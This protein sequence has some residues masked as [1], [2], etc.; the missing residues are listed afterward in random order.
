VGG[1]LISFTCKNS[2]VSSESHR[3]KRAGRFVKELQKSQKYF[4]TGCIIG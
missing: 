3:S 4:T 1:W 2:L